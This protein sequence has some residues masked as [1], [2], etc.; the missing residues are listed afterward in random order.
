MLRLRH[1]LL[2]LYKVESFHS[3]V[4]FVN[5]PKPDVNNSLT[6]CQEDRLLLL[7][8][9][10]VQKHQHN[11]PR[12]CRYIQCNFPSLVPKVF[13]ERILPEVNLYS[14]IQNHSQL[15]TYLVYDLSIIKYYMTKYFTY[16]FPS[17]YWLFHELG[18][19]HT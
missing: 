18:R 3:Y 4:Q 17:T 7:H 11:S 13:L 10:E 8:H 6:V 5:H 16:P 19:Y 12:L 2:G 15:F 1:H 14:N 9:P